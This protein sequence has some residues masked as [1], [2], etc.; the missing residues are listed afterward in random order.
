MKVIGVL[1]DEEVS[2]EGEKPFSGQSNESYSYFSERARE[3][4][5][6]LVQAHYE[7]YKDGALN[8]AWVFDGEWRKVENMELDGVFD[9]FH[10]DEDTKKIKEDID[11]EVG[12]INDPE[13]EQLCKDKLMTYER[14]SERI[15]ATRKFSEENTL[16]ML[17]EYGKV[18]L[19][20]RFAFGGKGIHILEQGDEV[21]EIESRYIVQR[22]VDS[23]G[24][25]EEIVDGTH[26]LRAIIVNGDLKASYVRYS[27]DGE[28]SNVAQGGSQ[29]SIDLEKFPDSALELVEEVYQEISFD[30]IF[31]SVDI[32]F[33]SDGRPW[34]VELNSKPG[35]GYYGD[36]K[37]KR[38][39]EPVM[40][41][42]AEALKQL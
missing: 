34:I 28:I 20:P 30:P 4:G 2:W 12:I 22:F 37:M 23:S 29:H 9:K 10:F 16:E 1:W 41:S 26:D 8:Q 11:V 19:K 39:L 6:K 27:E 14:F 31:F 17:G 33:D 40:D 21:P 13:L 35:I 5:V 25:I 42:L 3:K 18:V 15:P 32:F 38:R 36:Q 7:W 24:G